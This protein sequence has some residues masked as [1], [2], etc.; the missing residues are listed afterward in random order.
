MKIKVTKRR[1]I[2]EMV[3]V[4][5]EKSLQELIEENDKLV[6][7]LD[8]QFNNILAEIKIINRILRDKLDREGE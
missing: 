2:T 8:D 5:R 1:S 4:Q 7:K 3:E 6:K